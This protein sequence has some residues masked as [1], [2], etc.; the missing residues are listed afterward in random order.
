MPDKNTLKYYENMYEEYDRFSSTIDMKEQ[1]GE[2]SSRL[3]CGARVL[4]LGCG[5]GRDIK[6]FLGLGFK[7]D[8]LEPSV[9]MANYARLKTGVEI[10][11][12]AAEQIEFVEEYDGVWACAS[13]MHMR[14][15][16]FSEVLPRIVTA[17]KFGGYFYL[18]LKRGSGEVRNADGRLF[19]F[20]E[21][22]E[23]IT[24]FSRIDHT[25]VAE[26]WLSKDVAGRSETQWIN[27][28]VRRLEKKL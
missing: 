11:D 12:L 14:K 1:W 18:S 21:M 6:H 19:S 17:L 23:V 2:F 5:T 27:I 26:Q 9:A 8:G 25:Q 10:F 15:S 3:P 7:V 4:D 13:L 24:I 20:Y 28:L 16:V 22:D